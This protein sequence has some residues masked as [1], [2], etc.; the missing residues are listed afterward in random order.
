MTRAGPLGKHYKGVPA[1]RKRPIRS[2]PRANGNAKFLP[3]GTHG[4]EAPMSAVQMAKLLSQA[5]RPIGPAL[6]RKHVKQG[7]PV[8]KRGRLRLTSYVAW[9][10]SRLAEQR[11]RRN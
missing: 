7:A 11:R 9:L 10:V 8:D 2:G 1:M 5:R 4:L 3:A 6:I